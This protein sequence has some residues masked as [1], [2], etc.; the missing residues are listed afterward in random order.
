MLK[1]GGALCIT[2]DGPRGPAQIAQSGPVIM[3][4]RTD[5]PI[6][7]YAIVSEPEK[8]LSTWDGF[9]IPFPFTR[10]AIVFGAPIFPDATLDRESLRQQLEDNL[11]AATQRAYAHLKKKWPPEMDGQV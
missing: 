9:R 7:P 10:G 11:N 3:A 8:R 2:P 5:T 1:S 4:L 6:I